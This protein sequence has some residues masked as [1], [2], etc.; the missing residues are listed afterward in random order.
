[1]TAFIYTATYHDLRLTSDVL[2]IFIYQLEVQGT[3]FTFGSKIV[4]QRFIIARVS[5]LLRL[6]L[7]A[8]RVCRRQILLDQGLAE[9]ES[10]QLKLYAVG[11]LGAGDIP[12]SCTRYRH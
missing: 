8:S 3:V 5:Q 2:F 10:T 9:Q 4:I 6:G 1:M 12:V 7:R 11:K